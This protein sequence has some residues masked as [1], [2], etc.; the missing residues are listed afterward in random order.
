MK[1][2]PP[3]RN[4]RNV[5]AIDNNWRG[6]ITNKHNEV[7]QYE[8]FQELI[9]IMKL[10]KDDQVENYCSQ[11]LTISFVDDKGHQRRYT[12]DFKVWRADGS[13]EIHEMTI[14]DRQQLPATRQREEMG[15][16]VFS[17][18]GWKYVVHNEKSLPS[19]THI[20][21]LLALMRYRA[22][23]YA[24]AEVE[25]AA[26]LRVS[27]QPIKMLPLVQEL[28][29]ALSLPRALVVSALCHYIWRDLFIINYERLLFEDATVSP[30]A[31]IWR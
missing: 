19:T 1:R 31:T 30:K 3:K 11:P 12:P 8:S 5:A 18:S 28:C 29:A 23:G 21:N 20:T 9:L 10:E 26:K 17:A 16:Q 14:S 22:T 4:V 24:H 6:I 13:I 7:V 15:Y 27:A 25:M 2:R